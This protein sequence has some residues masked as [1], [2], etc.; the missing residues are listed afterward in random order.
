[1]RRSGG[2]S[3]P[4]ASRGKLPLWGLCCTLGLAWWEVVA[5]GLAESPDKA[6]S[7]LRGRRDTGEISRSFSAC[8]DG[9]G[10]LQ[11]MEAG[12]RWPGGA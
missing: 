9:A 3:P 2:A 4:R 1:M 7:T 8:L 12:Q 6:F 10:G 5:L 11:R